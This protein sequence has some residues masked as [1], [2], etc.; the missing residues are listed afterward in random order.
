[1][2]RPR[3]FNCCIESWELGVGSGVCY[4]YAGRDGGMGGGLIVLSIDDMACIYISINLYIKN[5]SPRDGRPKLL[6]SFRIQC[7]LLWNNPHGEIWRSSCKRPAKIGPVLLAYC[8]TAVSR[9]LSWY[10]LWYSLSFSFVKTPV[11]E[12][13][14]AVVANSSKK[15][16]LIA[17]R[18]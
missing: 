11:A 15:V 4:I 14:I 1:M 12:I 9:H 17:F 13:R 5:G 8:I 6:V 2:E 3:R 10:F 7:F 16:Y 18:N